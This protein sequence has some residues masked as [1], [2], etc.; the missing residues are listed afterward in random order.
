[1][2]SLGKPAEDPG[3]MEKRHDILR[4]AL[5]LMLKEM[6]GYFKTQRLPAQPQVIMG[7]GLVGQCGDSGR[8]VLRD[9]EERHDWMGTDRGLEEPVE[10]PCF[11]HPVLKRHQVRGLQRRRSNLVGNV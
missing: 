7:S 3:C 10:R 2:G 4:K 9:V 8:A 6:D 5:D 11:D 1:M